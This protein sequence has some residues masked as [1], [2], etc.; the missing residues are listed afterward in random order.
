M[1]SNKRK[2]DEIKVTI[3][4]M[5][6]LAISVS[7]MLRKIGANVVLPP[8]NNKDALTLGTRH[9]IETVCL[10]YKL[11][12]G[13]FI[14]ALENG[15]NTILMFQA[16]GTCRL[17]NYAGNIEAK[18]IELGYDFDMVIF[19][20]YKGKLKEIATK[21]AMVT[22][23]TNFVEIIQGFSLGFTKFDALDI[24]ERRLFYSRPRELNKGQSEKVYNKG[25]KAIDKAMSIKEVKQAVNN[26]L[27]EFET[28]PLDTN[29][30]VLTVHLTG[31]FYVLLDPFTNMEIEKEL[32]YLG[33]QVDRQVMLS[34]WTNN[35]LLPKFLYRKMSHRDRSVLYASK[36][37]NYMLRAIGGDCIESIG[38]AVF[39]SR[40]EIDGVIHV[41]PFNCNPEIVSQ[42]VLPHV[43]RNEDIPVL[44]LI[45]D[46]H[47]GKAGMITRLEAFV[48]LIH[49]R[50]R[51]KS[52][53]FD[54]ELVLCR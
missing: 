54:K 48:D 37:T 1:A 3:P 8:N 10:P 2:F 30:D 9:S 7:G 17:G 49:R 33:C 27:E 13:N 36:H 51:T 18:L 42:S 15:A 19:D 47:T 16:P 50:N 5:G 43:S 44:S 22:E 39:A 32:G 52:K 29:K 45:M 12:L 4:Q 34:D 41:G 40:Q 14:Q 24:I 35:A 53:S 31:E 26:T 20:C 38:D 6:N 46:E 11:I 21:F 25:R 23:K 28:A